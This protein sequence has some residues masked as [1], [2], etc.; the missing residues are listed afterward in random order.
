M[1]IAKENYFLTD[2][3]VCHGSMNTTL[4]DCLRAFHASEFKRMWFRLYIG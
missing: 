3:F 4:E 2:L 1:N